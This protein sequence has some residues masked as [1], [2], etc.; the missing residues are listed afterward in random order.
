[1]QNTSN[2]A[3]SGKV[4]EDLPENDTKDASSNN[5]NATVE[6][7]PKK[8]GFL[9]A[10]TRKILKQ[11]D[12]REALADFIDDN[13]D[14]DKLDYVARHERDLISNVLKL[15]DMTVY[16]V[17]VPRVDI[18]SIDVDSNFHDI[19]NIVLEKQHSR[20]PVYK[21]N[22]DNTFGFIHLKDLLNRD[23]NDNT[24]DINSIVRELPI[25]S[26]SLPVLDLLLQMKQTKLHMAL[27]IDEFGGI[28]GLVTIEDITEAIVGEISDEFDTEKE[29]ELIIK[30]E[31][32]SIIADA[33]I[34]LDDLMDVTKIT[35][36]SEEE[37][38]DIDTLGG[39]ITNKIGRVPARGEVLRDRR[40]GIIFEIIEADPRRISRVRIRKL[41]H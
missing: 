33:R 21:D 23:L 36:G 24:F 11:G 27:V 37:L 38:D 28:D 25:L 12:I 8:N 35:L 22:L 32:S 18:V 26:P 4:I 15:R 2:T 29:P 5:E 31:D 14:D 30:P 1:M 13:N 41:N 3:P 39:Y 16:D 40:N 9:A 7:K 20:I 34:E 17:M 10:I 6:T 19:I